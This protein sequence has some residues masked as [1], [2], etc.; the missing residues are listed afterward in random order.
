M[1]KHQNVRKR[2]IALLLAIVMIISLIHPNV[3]NV[4]FAAEDEEE[5][6]DITDTSGV[7]DPSDDEGKDITDTSG[8]GDPSDDEGKDIIDTSGV[9]DPSDDEGKD[10]TDTFSVGNLSDGEEK[11]TADITVISENETSEITVKDGSTEDLTL[12]TRI[13]SSGCTITIQAPAGS[14]PYPENELTVTA[15]EITQGTIEYQSYLND[16]AEAMNRENDNILSARFFDIEI[17]RNGEKIEPE[18]PVETKIEYDEA[19]EIPEGAELSVVHF[20][21]EGTEVIED[22]EVNSDATEIV[23]DQESFSVTATIVTQTPDAKWNGTYY[24]LAVKYEGKVYTVQMD[25]SL[26][27]TSAHT[28]TAGG[29]IDTVTI[30]NPRMWTYIQKDSKNYLRYTADG[31]DYDEYM[32]LPNTFSYTYIDPTVADGITSETVKKDEYGNPLVIGGKTQFDSPVDHCAIEIDDQHHIHTS[33]LE[34]IAIDSSGSKIVGGLSPFN[35]DQLAQI[36]KASFYL[37]EVKAF[38]NDGDTGSWD[39]Y[40]VFL[41]RNHQVNHI[42]IEIKKEVDA[43]IPLAYGV[44]YNE[45]GIPILQITEDTPAD[46]KYIDV[47]QEVSVSQEQLRK[48]EI[49]ATSVDNEG[50]VK[51]LPDAFYINGFSSN[52][53]TELSKNQV[54]IEGAFKVADLPYTDDGGSDATKSERLKH[55]VTYTVTA[56]EQ[57]VSFEY[58]HPTLGKLYDS[59]HHL[60]VIKGDVTISASFNYWDLRN[61]CPP[62][63]NFVYDDWLAGGIWITGM[64]GMD[65]KLQGDATIAFQP[66]S[67]EINKAVIDEQGNPIIPKEAIS[68]LTFH[69]YEN[70]DAHPDDVINLDVGSYTQAPDYTG[71]VP[72]DT[73]TITVNTTDG[74]GIEHDTS[75]SPGMVYI[76]EDKDSVPDQFTDATG[77]IWVYKNTFIETEYVWRKE[78]DE[79]KPRHISDVYDK[80][81]ATFASIPEVL[82]EY[83]ESNKND[84]LEFFV[85]NIYEKAEKP[86]KKEIAPYDGTGVLGGVKVG[87]IITYE[88]SYKNYKTVDADV[89]ISDHLDTNVEFIN[90]DNNGVYSDTDHKVNWT[91][92]GV[93]AGAS[94]KVT[95]QVKVLE[96]AKTT[97]D[98]MV[99]NGGATSTVKIGNDKE[100]TLNTVKNPV[101]DEPSKKET[102]PYD[103]TGVLDAV[104][105]GDEI[106]Y[107]IEYKNYKDEAANVVITDTL[108]ENVAFVSADNGGTVTNGIVTWTLE[109]VAKNTTGK[110]TLT[111]KVLPSACKKDGTGKVINGGDTSTVKVGNDN[112]YTLNTVE[113]PVPNT[114]EKQE[115]A[116]YQGTGYLGGV[117]VDEEITYTI[118]YENYKDEKA[119]I[120]IVDTLDKN[121]QYVSSDPAGSYDATLHKVTWNLKDVTAKTKGIV[122]LKVKVLKSALKSENGPG[123]VVNGGEGTTVQVGNGPVYTLETVQNPVPKT[124]IKQETAPYEG[125]GVLG[126]VKV[127]DDITYE[128]KYKNYKNEKADI[129][130]TDKL[131]TKVEFKEAT[132][133]GSHEGGIVTWN[134]KNVEAGAEGTVKVTVTV[135]EAASGKSVINGGD[136]TT[137]KVGNDNAQKLN[138]VENPVPENPSKKETAPYNGTGVLGAVKVG[139]TITYEISYKNYK[140]DAADIFINDTLDAKVQFVEADNE[141]SCS[142]ADAQTN[143]G[144]K[145]TWT[146]KDVPAGTEGTVTLKVKVLEGALTSKGGE[147]KVVNGGETATVKVGND[148]EYTLDVVENPVGEYVEEDPHKTETAPYEGNGILGAVKVGDEITY[149]ISYK[150]Y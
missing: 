33:E 46:E 79:L 54:R 92:S 24:A 72:A 149:E 12:R 30:D 4:I 13:E 129:Q 9:G 125:T 106:T 70:A 40:G 119:D 122:T 19:P 107:E 83:G 112:A 62:I 120:K 61:E 63:H 74:T 35:T 87:N 94:G 34:F 65:F 124:P 136:S 105:V 90:A 86:S 116:P 22:V 128:I 140:A 45:A 18:S 49:V 121:V 95:L 113:N 64:T 93:K 141:G 57:D 23:Y 36:N 78:G 51:V 7:G 145:V 127:G 2:W 84:F 3:R 5:V 71:Y 98:R 43:R 135:L 139:D 73:K 29:V 88:I 39:G 66:V 69:V 1:K 100:Y 10:I 56:T 118:S 48:A 76:T 68:G 85:Y 52:D 59:D 27:E 146:L 102:A 137:V 42:D 53:E 75:V 47:R 96:G 37:A 50:H 148:K 131:D 123:Y 26:V 82:G 110:V 20:A 89:V 103:G 81:D 15:R 142:G 101:P 55:P 134:L 16:A 117:D 133:G 44:Y 114:P 60:H 97:Q 91:L 144:G 67:I 115:T 147:G 6:R 8:V 104:K 17:L 21:D 11:D 150:N 130:I 31:Y 77:Q 32:K 111:V 80:S 138:T 41:Q 38:W 58:V 25:G 14:L 108:D 99:V 126:G 143:G 109:N 132:E 28:E